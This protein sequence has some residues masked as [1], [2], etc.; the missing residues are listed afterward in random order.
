MYENDD[1][2]HVRIGCM[3]GP[4]KGLPGEMER[5]THGIL[6]FWSV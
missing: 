6:Y 1:G 5:N 3:D 2:G 4:R